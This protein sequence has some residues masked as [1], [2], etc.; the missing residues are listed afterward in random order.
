MLHSLAALTRQGVLA[1][2]LVIGSGPEQQSLTTL[3]MSLGVA[4]RVH[5]L[6][7]RPDCAAILRGGVD[8]LVSGAREEVFGLTLAEAG[9]LGL[10]VSA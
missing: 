2:L 5:F 8:L 7:E 9:M 4:Q 6:G 3:A 10:A 1:Q